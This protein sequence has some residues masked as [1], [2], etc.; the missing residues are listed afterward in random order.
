MVNRRRNDLID[1]VISNTIYQYLN[2]LSTIEVVSGPDQE[3]KNLITFT[4]SFEQLRNNCILDY[5]P[6]Y[7]EF[8]R[9]YGY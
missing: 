9:S 1:P 7:E 4:K 2:L 6:E 5:L 3:R 8:L